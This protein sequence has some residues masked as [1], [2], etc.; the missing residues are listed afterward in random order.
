MSS[1]EGSMAHLVINDN[2]SSGEALVLGQILQLGD[3]TMGARS[4]VKPKV[5]PK[6]T[7]HHLRIGLEHSEKMDPADITS[8]NELLDRIATLECAA[9]AAGAG[10]RRP[11]HHPGRP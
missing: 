1:T 9:E 5:A 11:A 7:K 6:I 3:F 2:I 8:L 10:A 4:A